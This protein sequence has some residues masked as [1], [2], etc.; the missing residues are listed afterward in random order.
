VHL[1]ILRK[2]EVHA[3]HKEPVMFVTRILMNS[4]LC[5]LVHRL[6]QGV[7]LSEFDVVLWY[8]RK[9]SFIYTHKKSMAFPAPV[10]SKLTNAQQHYV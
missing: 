9:F 6:C 4:V 7:I 10:S 1:E 8:I 2:Y 5:D 3:H